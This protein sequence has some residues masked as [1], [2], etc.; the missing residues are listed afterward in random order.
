MAL[1][2]S[3]WEITNKSVSGKLDLIENLGEYVLVHFITK[4]NTSFITK[5]SRNTPFKSGQ[6]M[7]FK[8][9]YRYMHLF[10]KRTNNRVS[11]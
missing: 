5:M 10:G 9:E 2:F 4:N 1:T 11:T 7:F 3:H 8:A 6:N